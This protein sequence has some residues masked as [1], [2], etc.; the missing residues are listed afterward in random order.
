MCIY[1]MHG[2]KEHEKEIGLYSG[3]CKGTEPRKA[4]C[5]IAGTGD[6]KKRHFSG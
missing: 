4:V 2:G 6:W 3:I 5:C 1:T